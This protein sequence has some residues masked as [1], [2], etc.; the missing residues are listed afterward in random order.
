MVFSIL[1]HID[2]DG[3]FDQMGPLREHA[4]KYNESYSLDLTA[5]TDR[6]PLVLQVAILS[7]MIG[8]VTAKA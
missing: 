3:T 7:E 2:Q 1:R 4:S 5:A 8:P 6:L